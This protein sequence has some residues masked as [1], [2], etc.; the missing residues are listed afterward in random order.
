MKDKSKDI[1][2]LTITAEAAEHLVLQLP[3]GQRQFLE[4]RA[5]LSVDQQT[6]FLQETLEVLTT[7][8]CGREIHRRWPGEVK[9]Q[10]VSESLQSGAMVNE[11]AELYG[12]KPNHLTTWRTV[13][14]QG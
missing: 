3:E 5:M 2:H 12:W 13:A 6:E 4:G 8:K 7:K 10:I 11:V 1:G 14:P 9:A